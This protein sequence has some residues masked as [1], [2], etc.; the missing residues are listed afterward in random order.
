MCRV[1]ETVFLSETAIRKAETK[2]SPLTSTFSANSNDG[3]P[4]TRDKAPG[5]GKMAQE[6][7]A[8]A[9]ACCLKF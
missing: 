3:C 2:Y 1:L 5:A 7:S 9:Q 6:L 4:T 8:V